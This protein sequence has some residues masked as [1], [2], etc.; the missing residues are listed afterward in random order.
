MDENN[1]LQLTLRIDD[2]PTVGAMVAQKL[3]EAIMSGTPPEA[4]EAFLKS[5]IVEWGKIIKA[6]GIEPQ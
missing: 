3:R 5:E 6:A 2:V 1:D 4:L